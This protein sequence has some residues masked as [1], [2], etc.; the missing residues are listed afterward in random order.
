MDEQEKAFTIAA[1]KI[2]IKND[3]ERE[4]EIEKERGM[5]QIATIRTAIELQDH[6]TNVLYQVVQSVNLGLTAMENLQR[7]MNAPVDTVSMEMA[8]NS[9]NQAT[10]AVRELDAAMQTVSSPVISPSI[11]EVQTVYS[12]PDRK[13]S[14]PKN[15]ELPVTP[16]FPQ[17]P[18]INLPKELRVDITPYV[19]QQPEIDV[20][21]QIDV[22][23]TPL[24]CPMM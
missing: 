24:R 23:V 16:V 4:A 7:T 10:A 20:P 15:M 19:T 17:D 14:I 13:P 12:Q 18:S 3:K 11:A 8:R 6:F 1:I 21:K 22:P 9:I 5:I 2:K